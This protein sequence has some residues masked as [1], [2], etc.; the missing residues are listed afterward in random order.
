M[1]RFLGSVYRIT[2]TSGLGVHGVIPG[3]AN[4]VPSI[5]ARA[6]EAG[7]RGDDAAADKNLAALA[8][9]T[10]VISLASG[11]GAN[12][13]AMAGIKSALKHLGVIDH[14]T[15]TA[16]LRPLTA[17]EKQRIPPILD[18]LGLTQARR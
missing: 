2:T 18:D 11:G 15:L 6:W 7:E 12:S 16:P 8:S 1:Y 10:R 14:D 4:L 9:A 13:S 5:A 17:E 3:I